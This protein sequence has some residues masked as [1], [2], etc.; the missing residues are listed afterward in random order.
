MTKQPTLR[1]AA[2]IDICFVGKPVR[3]INAMLIMPSIISIQVPSGKRGLDFYRY[4]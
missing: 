2:Y 4:S 3:F 1:G